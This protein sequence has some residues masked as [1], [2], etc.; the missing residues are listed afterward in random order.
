MSATTKVMLRKASKRVLSLSEIIGKNRLRTTG[1]TCSTW[2]KKNFSVL[3]KSS[4][5]RH[6]GFL[7]PEPPSH[8]KVGFSTSTAK[9][10]DPHPLPAVAYDYIDDDEADHSGVDELHG[11]TINSLTTKQDRTNE[12][13]G[14]VTG[15]VKD[16]VNYVFSR[17]NCTTIDAF[18]K[19]DSIEN[20]SLSNNP[21]S[22][23]L[24]FSSKTNP[25]LQSSNISTTAKSSNGG[26]IG[27]GDGTIYPPPSS[28]EF[29]GEVGGKAFRKG[30]GGGGG[31]YR[32]PKCGTDVTFKCDFEDN[33]FYC[34]SCAGWFAGTR[35]ASNPRQHPSAVHHRHEQSRDD[36][37]IYEEFIAKDMRKNEQKGPG[38]AGSDQEIIMRHVSIPFEPNMI[39]KIFFT[40]NASLVITLDDWLA[41]APTD[42]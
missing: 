24:A 22:P 31:R 29:G 40:H 39:M 13:A 38:D 3:A 30:S 15:A 18:K 28:A 11:R 20:Q 23:P 37:S 12:I 35:T 1:A 41:M 4:S 9:L 14:G 6:E 10:S 8:S 25:I 7:V 19:S 32:C 36:G 17:R 33:T 2:G 42:S 27:G 34:A 21:S 5:L 26:G 16:D